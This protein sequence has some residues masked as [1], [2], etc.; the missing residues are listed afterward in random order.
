[1]VLWRTHPKSI[2]TVA[3]RPAIRIG[4][5]CE[6]GAQLDSRILAGD[7]GLWAADRRVTSGEPAY[8]DGRLLGCLGSVG[9]AGGDRNC[10]GCPVRRPA[11]ARTYPDDRP[12]C[13][14]AWPFGADGHFKSAGGGIVEPRG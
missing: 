8:A 1:M 9:R 5:R 11:R 2:G 6:R 13:R 10:S 12:P 4:P 7:G 14:A 3:T